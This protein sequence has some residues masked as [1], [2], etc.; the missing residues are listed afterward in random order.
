[1]LSW[2]LMIVVGFISPLIFLLIDKDKPFVYRHAAQ[3]LSLCITLIPVY[4]GMLILGILLAFLGPLALL[5]VPLWLAVAV[6]VIVAVVMGAVNANKGLEFS[7]PIS[8][9]VCKA[10]FKV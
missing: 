7:P 8:G 6:G 1:M 4:I 10:L 5:I 2:I 3:G 9:A